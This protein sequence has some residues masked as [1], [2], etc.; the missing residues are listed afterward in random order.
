[1]L[2]VPQQQYGSWVPDAFMKISAINVLN[3]S[4]PL[5]CR[6]IIYSHSL[7][8]DSH[9]LPIDISALFLGPSMWLVLVN[10]I[11]A[12]WCMPHPIRSS[13]SHCT[14]LQF[15]CSFSLS[16]DSMSQIGVL[17]E[18]NIWSQAI[19][20]NQLLC[21]WEIHPYGCKIW[22]MIWR[23]LIFGLLLYEREINICL[24]TLFCVFCPSGLNWIVTN[25]TF[26]L[27]PE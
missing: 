26:Y 21:E 5:T 27:I 13:K 22:R 15:S 12:E 17:A 9:Y 25:S 6:R 7:P 8:C 1:M 11:W 3:Y 14:F 16:Q 20:A 19:A 18:K 2:R 10:E 23:R 4:R 24:E